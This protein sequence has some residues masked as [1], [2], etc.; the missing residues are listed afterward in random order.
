MTTGAAPVEKG[1]FKEATAVL[2]HAA[3]QDASNAYTT[4]M[5]ENARWRLYSFYVTSHAS[6]MILPR[7]TV[8]CAI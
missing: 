4:E 2:L 6:I 1:C 7:L 3:T 5:G 8:G